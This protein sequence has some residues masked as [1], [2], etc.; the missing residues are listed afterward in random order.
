MWQSM[1]H[2]FVEEFVYDDEV[3]SDG[4]LVEG[5]EIVLKE[6]CELVEV[7]E[8]QCHIGVFACDAAEIE[9]VVLDRKVKDGDMY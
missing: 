4:F 2:G 1:I 7:S 3:V 5:C 8:D 9:V 6:G